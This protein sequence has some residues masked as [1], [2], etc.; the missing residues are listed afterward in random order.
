MVRYEVDQDKRKK[1]ILMLKKNESMSLGEINKEISINKSTIKHHMSNLIENNAVVKGSFGY[2]L[3]NGNIDVEHNFDK[4]I[5]EIRVDLITIL[6]LGIMSVIIGNL[7]SDYIIPFFIGGILCIIPGFVYRSKI[8]L[9]ELDYKNI[10]V[11]TGE[12][13]REKNIKES[14]SG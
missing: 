4:Y 6:F 7:Y 2:T 14:L 12:T 9:S 5:K 8:A 11:E 10:Y 1:I 3:N 13:E